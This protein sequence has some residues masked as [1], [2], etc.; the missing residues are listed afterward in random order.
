DRSADDLEARSLAHLL[1][2]PTDAT[3]V[4]NDVLPELPPHIVDQYIHGVAF[5][6][7][8]PIVE[9]I[10][11]LAPGEDRAGSLGQRPQQGELLQRK[12]DR[13][14]FVGYFVAR[15]IKRHRTSCD[16]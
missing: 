2:H 6:L 8:S 11:Q 1:N 3:D 16:R 7:V 9:A 13:Q 12:N 14:S 5:D 10:L 4:L 15:E